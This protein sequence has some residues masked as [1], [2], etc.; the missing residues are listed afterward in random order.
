MNLDQATPEGVEDELYVQALQD[1]AIYDVNVKLAY[2]MYK[3]DKI[4]DNMADAIAI[5]AEMVG[6]FKIFDI[7]K[8]DFVASL[9]DED[10]M[11]GLR[12]PDT[13]LFPG[14]STYTKSQFQVPNGD[15]GNPT[16]TKDQW[17]YV[18]GDG[19]QTGWAVPNRLKYAN[20]STAF[21]IFAV[22]AYFTGRPLLNMFEKDWM[23]KAIKLTLGVVG[24]YHAGQ[25]TKDRFETGYEFTN[26]STNSILSALSARKSDLASNT[27]FGN[28]DVLHT[29]KLLT[30]A[31]DSNSN[32]S[33]RDLIDYI[34]TGKRDGESVPF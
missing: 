28:E 9:P 31:L 25:V 2:F 32:A 26:E 5:I 22:I 3:L 6:N 7:L 15:P 13:P 1:G 24:S 23:K 29:I 16:A 12:Y 8:V 27:A 33:V 10:F 14:D 18:D 30:K 34:D 21:I 19:R 11:T 17:Q 4:C 20:M